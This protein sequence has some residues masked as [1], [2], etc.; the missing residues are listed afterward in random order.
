M[1]LSYNTAKIIFVNEDAQIDTIAA[2]LQSKKEISFD[3]EFDRFWREYG[4]KLF[5]L[6]IFDGEICYL[7]DPLAIKNLQPIWAV[8]ENENIC[9]VAY[10]CLEDV[11]LLKLHGCYIKNVYDVQVLAKL[12]NHTSNSFAELVADKCNIQV[13]KTYQRSNWRKRP[14]LPDQLIYASNDVIW[15]L[16]IKQQLLANNFNLALQ[17]MLQEE[18][19]FCQQATVTEYTVKLT[20]K[21][22]ATFSNYHKEILLQLF[23]ERN[24]I[25]IK[26]NVPPATIIHDT[27][28][29]KF[30]NDKQVFQ[31]QGFKYG[32]SSIVLENEKLQEIFT[33]III[34]INDTIPNIAERRLT[35]PHFENYEARVKRKANADILCK[36][37][38]DLVKEKYGFIT[39]EYIMRGIKRELQVK[40]YKEIKLRQYQHKVFEEICS[41]INNESSV[42]N[43]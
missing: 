18:N 29:E 12:S 42:I 22:Q 41:C 34:S 21:Q 25:A 2:T 37:V 9:K 19:I 36:T 32:F 20:S 7:I 1:P 30:V 33:K 10:A 17:Y 28:L 43:F 31:Q 5:L 11:Q 14:L 13:D 27:Y 16:Q 23:N 35:N 26:Y 4:F 6:Q 8:F 24:T 3:T 15:L 38:A 40:P 39:G